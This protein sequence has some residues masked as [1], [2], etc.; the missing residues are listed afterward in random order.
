MTAL[1]LEYQ[2]KK[3]AKDTAQSMVDK[4]YYWN[5]S[6]NG[7]EI[8]FRKMN[9]MRVSRVHECKGW[10]SKPQ[11]VVEYNYLDTGLSGD[12]DLDYFLHYTKPYTVDSP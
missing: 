8:A 12:Q 2:D 11:L 10:N 9:L 1:F 3:D 7:E 4:L 6:S 5:K